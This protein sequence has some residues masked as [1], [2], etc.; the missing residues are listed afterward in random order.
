MRRSA[1]ILAKKGRAVSAA[2]IQVSEPVKTEEISTDICKSREITKFGSIVVELNE[3]TVAYEETKGDHEG[4]PCKSGDHQILQKKEEKPKG[5]K[6]QTEMRSAIRE[7][8]ETIP[9]P[10]ISD[11]VNGPEKGKSLESE[12]FII[13]SKKE[14]DLK[15]TAGDVKTVGNSIKK[16]ANKSVLGI[17]EKGIQSKSTAI[18]TDLNCKKDDGLFGISDWALPIASQL[19]TQER[20][21][22]KEKHSKIQSEGKFALQSNSSNKTLLKL[23]SEIFQ[24]IPFKITKEDLLANKLPKRNGS[25]SKF[26]NH[27]KKNKVEEDVL[28][29]DVISVTLDDKEISDRKKKL[30][31]LSSE[32]DPRVEPNELYFKL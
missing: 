21:L 11:S 5:V 2:Q 20:T 17:K 12:S 19:N 27:D 1:R 9:V 18:R 4:Q 7:Q 28:Q 32:L 30:L 24:K 8:Q 29:K 3:N 15:K 22:L 16:E 14:I 13:L 23:T 31:T 25:K 26:T 6:D 10:S